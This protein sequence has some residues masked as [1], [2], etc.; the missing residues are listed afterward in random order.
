MED[1]ATAEI[2][3]S[4]VWQWVT[5]GVKLPDGRPITAAVVRQAI[6]QE[7]AA[8]PGTANK[9]V[10]ADLFSEMMTRSDF[11]EFLTTAAYQKID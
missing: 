3:R 6:D 5:H 8:K 7:L 1:A 2:S 4:Q 10:A 11:Q 9:K